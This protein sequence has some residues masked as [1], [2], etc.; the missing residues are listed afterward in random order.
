[1]K[2]LNERD[3][4]NTLGV[5][6]YLLQRMRCRGDGPSFCRIGGCVRYPQDSLSDYVKKNMCKSTS[7]EM[8]SIGDGDG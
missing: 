5:S 7:E 3:A 2:L 4:A 8:K 6:V 1:M